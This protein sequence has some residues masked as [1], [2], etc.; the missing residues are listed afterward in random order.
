MLYSEGVKCWP[1][2][3]TPHLFED[4]HTLTR[5]LS[6]RPPCVWHMQFIICDEN[7]P[8]PNT[9][10]QWSLALLW[11]I[12]AN[13]CTDAGLSRSVRVEMR[14]ATESRLAAVE[15]S[16][17]SMRNRK[18]AIRDF[19]PHT[20]SIIVSIHHLHIVLFSNRCKLA[21]PISLGRAMQGKWHPPL[22]SHHR[23]SQRRLKK[24]ANVRTTCFSKHRTP[25]LSRTW[26][27]QS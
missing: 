23:I 20:A 5:S 10:W 2:G 16:W 26:S 13:N 18:H 17:S 19:L 1:E 22:F 25:A 14:C 4:L 8:G 11:H 15:Q 9:S 3:P 27:C 12:C 21:R 24:T 7:N 6:P